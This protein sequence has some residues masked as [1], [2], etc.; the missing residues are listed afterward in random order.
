VGAGDIGTHLP[1]SDPQWK[2]AATKTESHVFDGDRA[3]VRNSALV[4]ALRLLAESARS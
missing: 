4:T 2:G 1:P 3:A